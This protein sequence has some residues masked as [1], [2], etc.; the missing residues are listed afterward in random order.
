MKSP[1]IRANDIFIKD[2]RTRV[3][4]YKQQLI[5][6]NGNSSQ[7]LLRVS[8]VNDLNFKAMFF[9]KT[10][11][12]R[13]NVITYLTITLLMVG[14][15]FLESA[16]SEKSQVADCACPDEIQVTTQREAGWFWGQHN[17]ENGC[18]RR[19]FG[20]TISKC[21]VECATYD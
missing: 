13:K 20:I 16:L 15:I 9:V 6:A 19:M 2:E 17:T 10:K 12:K 3:N 4:K 1:K 14:G 11:S 7:A 21:K 18:V 5:I 8:E